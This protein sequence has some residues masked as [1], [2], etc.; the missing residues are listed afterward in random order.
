MKKVTTPYRPYLREILKLLGGLVALFVVA[1]IVAF[2]WDGVEFQYNKLFCISV[3]ANAQETEEEIIELIKTEY[4]EYIEDFIARDF[5]A[6]A[7][8][9]QVPTMFRAPSLTVVTSHQEIA[10]RYA[11]NP[12]QEGYEYTTAD[13]LD[14]HKLSQDVYY[15]DVDFRRYNDSDEVILQ[16][17]S[18]Y[19]FSKDTGS[20]KMFYMNGPTNQK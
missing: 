2:N 18:I 13:R 14:V 19:F 8:H 5:E 16:S 12:I 3:A 15:A 9:F 4:M 20:W 11:N 17:R 1:G 7:T 6:V 10:Q